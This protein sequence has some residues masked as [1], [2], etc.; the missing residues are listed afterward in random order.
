MLRAFCLHLILLFVAGLTSVTYASSVPQL[1]NYQGK[2]TDDEGQALA[3][4]EYSLSFSI[5]D[6][7]L[8][9]ANLVWGAQVFDGADQMGHGALVPVVQGFFN[10][11][12][13]PYDE[14]GDPIVEA[15]DRPDRYLEITVGDGSPILPRQQILSAPYALQSAGDVPVGTVLPFMGDV[16]LLPSNW[17]FCD[18]TIIDDPDSPLDGQSLPDL[19]SRFLRGTSSEGLG[20]GVSA[21]SDFHSHYIPSGN[22]TSYFPIVSGSGYTNAYHPVTSASAFDSTLRNL[23]APEGVSPPYST[24]GHTDGVVFGSTN[25]SFAL[26]SYL[27]IQFIMRIK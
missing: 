21:G 17:V 9:G 24:H 1:I 25:T 16:S 26:P 15:F 5:Y 14:D 18:G 3:T 10:V 11:I 12:L 27:S 2:L 22:M 23:T 4:A 7:P 6:G 8:D 19:R 20:V 13:G